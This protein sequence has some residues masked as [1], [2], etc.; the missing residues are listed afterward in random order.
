MTNP[1]Y[2]AGDDGPGVESPGPSSFPLTLPPDE[3]AV[4]AAQ[5]FKER[6]SL[7]GRYA[8]MLG[9]EG[10]VRGLIDRVLRGRIDR[11]FR[12]QAT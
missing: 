8:E 12:G 4:A 9:T 1:R 10:V 7:A 5:V 3:I 2:G 11:V 6:L